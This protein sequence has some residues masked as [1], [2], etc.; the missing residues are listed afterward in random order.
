[1]TRTKK[2]F[3]FIFIIITLIIFIIGFVLNMLILNNKDFVIKEYGFYKYVSINDNTISK[4]NS[5]AIIGVTK[6]G[7]NEQYLHIPREIDGHPVKYIGYDEGGGMGLFGGKRHYHP[8]SGE[9]IKKLY[10]YDNI[11][12]IEDVFNCEQTD[13]MLCRDD[14]T[15]NP[16]RY[17]CFKDVYV[18]NVVYDNMN[19]NPR[20]FLLANILFMNNFPNDSQSI[21]SIDNIDENEIIK[22]PPEP[23]LNGHKFTG[24][25][26][27][28]ECINSF[29]FS[30]RQVIDEK[31][32]FKLYAGWSNM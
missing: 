19:E 9:G 25:F 7:K 30:E 32:F 8:F 29:H 31:Q 10:V 15:I 5:I 22:A 2:C 20:G 13:L 14:I 6:S 11:E 26:T 21:Y 12:I 17:F 28:P 1:M 24:W 18:N 16:F 27:E 3:T 4:D 23:K